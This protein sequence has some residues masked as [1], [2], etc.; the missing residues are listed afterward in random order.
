MNY[1]LFGILIIIWGLMYCPLIA[2]QTDSLTDVRNNDSTEVSPVEEQLDLSEL[3]EIEAEKSLFNVKDDGKFVLSWKNE[4]NPNGQLD[5]EVNGVPVK[6]QLK[7]GKGTITVAS[8]DLEDTNVFTY[9]NVEVA[10]IDVHRVNYAPWLSLLP[11]LIAILLALVFREV[12]VSLFTGIFLGAG[13]LALSDAND[14]T[15]LF[16]AFLTSLDHYLVD[17]LVDEDHVSIILFSLLI[18]GMVAIISKNGGM[19]GIVNRISRIAK[20]ARSGQIAT[21]LLGVVIFFDDYANSL[22]VGNTMRNITDKLKISREKLSYIVDSTAAPVSALAFISTWIA[23][24][25]SYIEDGMVQLSG[26]PEGLSPYRVFL[27]SLPYSFYPILTLVFILL[28]I[29]TGKDFGPMLKAEQRA[30]TTGVVKRENENSKVSEEVS[31]FEPIEGI[32]PKAFNAVIPVS[33]LVVG[34]LIGLLFTGWDQEIWEA[35]DMGFAAKISAI[36][37][38]SNSYLALMWASLSAVVVALILTLSQR[39]MSLVDSISVMT[40]GFKAML[41]ALIILT[42]AWGL[43][44]VTS[45]VYTADFLTDLLSDNLSPVWLPVIAFVLG[46]MVSFSTGSSW[47]TMAILYPLVIP[48]AWKICLDY[49][50]PVDNAMAI[51]A[52]VVASILAGSVLGDHCSPISDTTILSSLACDVNH[53]D[54]VRTQ[55][56]YALVVGVIAI[57]VGTIPSA[58][59]IPTWICFLF[60]VAALFVIIRYY[61]KYTQ[62]EG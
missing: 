32:K 8:E 55:L 25:L 59:G 58:F 17:A 6:V 18:G 48:L 54:H 2:Q 61:G 39:M 23:A 20:T 35:T 13:I 40:G 22:V 3:I 60:G 49:G 52:N 26:L 7:E 34:V 15:S 47:G 14:S 50:L 28:L 10:S 11:P 33:V 30:R 57:L 29:F 44:G 45:D 36:I 38:K 1:R 53:I 27:M 37:G 31:H 51:F 12:V 4:T 9:N 62:A 56:P 19:L 21:W 42:L 43:Q 5:L 16:S 24:E 46:A 41:P